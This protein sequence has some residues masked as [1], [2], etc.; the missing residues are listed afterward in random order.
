MLKA[1]NK[2]SLRTFFVINSFL[3]DFLKI[4]Y[5][6]FLKASLE[7]LVSG[8]KAPGAVA[9]RTRKTETSGDATGSLFT[10]APF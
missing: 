8:A 6:L 5:S 1:E 3:V 9:G 4:V 7:C 2:W 10:L